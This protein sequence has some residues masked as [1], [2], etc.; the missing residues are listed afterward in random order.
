MLVVISILGIL[1]MVVTM[2]MVGLTD[3]ARKRASDGELSTIQS[4]MDAMMLDQQ[5]DPADVCTGAPPAGTADMSQFPNGTG[6]SQSGAGVAVRLYPHYLR[7]QT[8]NRAYVCAA[9]AVVR[10]APGS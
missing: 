10:P 1:A 7:K 6:W 4:A 8:M 2:S 9:G 3:L 5:I